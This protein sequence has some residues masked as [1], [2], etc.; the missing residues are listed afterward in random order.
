MISKRLLF[1]LGIRS[2][3]LQVLWNFERMQNVGF[4]YIIMP[5]LR[6]IYKSKEEFKKSV[7]RHLEFFNVHPYMVG[8]IVGLV[9][10]YE[11]KMQKEEKDYSREISTLKSTM[12]GPLAAIGDT[13]FWGLWRPFSASVVITLYYLYSFESYSENYYFFLI[14]LFLILY[15]TPHFLVRFF[16]IYK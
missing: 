13:F 8:F 16:G 12:A 6:E 2:F 5:A 4:A 3:F 7:K 14:A 10:L 9:V 15:N 11:E 1:Y